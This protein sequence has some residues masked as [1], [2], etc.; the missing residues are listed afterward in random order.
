MLLNTN[1]DRALFEGAREERSAAGI[2]PAQARAAMHSLLDGWAQRHQTRTALREL[3]T[4]LR[5]CVDTQASQ[6]DLET[7]DPDDVALVPSDVL[8]RLDSVERID[9]PRRCNADAV[10]RWACCPP[11]LAVLTAH[12]IQA[13]PNRALDLRAAGRLHTFATTGELQVEAAINVTIHRKT[14]EPPDKPLVIRAGSL[15]CTT[16]ESFMSHANA[17]RLA[18][19]GQRAQSL[20]A[21]LQVMC[22]DAFHAEMN[23]L[24]AARW[25][26]AAALKGLVGLILDDDVIFAAAATA[27]AAA[28]E[29]GAPD[30]RHLPALFS[31]CLLAV[32]RHSS[33]A[34]SDSKILN[35]AQRLAQRLEATGPQAQVDA[36]SVSAHLRAI[37]LLS[38]SGVLT[39]AN[40]RVYAAAMTLVA[41]VDHA[42]FTETATLQSLADAF[43]GLQ[44]ICTAGV[45]SKNASVL[46]A[47]GQLA[48]LVNTAPAEAA[49][50][51]EAVPGAMDGL[52]SAL[53]MN[54]VRADQ[55]ALVGAVARLAMLATHMAHH[56]PAAFRTTARCLQAFGELVHRHALPDES[57]RE[58]TA[59]ALFQ[60]LREAVPAEMARATDCA[61]AL[62]GI[63]TLIEAH[64]LS[65]RT[66]GLSGTVERLAGNL[67]GAPGDTGPVEVL[68][69]LDHLSHL[70]DS[71]AIDDTSLLQACARLI[72]GIAADSMLAA[73]LG[74]LA[75]GLKALGD[76]AAK[77][78][79]ARD[80]RALQT[81][82]ACLTACG[83]NQ[84]FSRVDATSVAP[85]GQAVQHAARQGLLDHSFLQ[86]GFA[87]FAAQNSRGTRRTEKI[88]SL[89]LMAVSHGWLAMPARVS[90]LL[91]DRQAMPAPQEAALMVEQGVHYLRRERILCADP[92]RW[93][94]DR[95]VYNEIMRLAP[96]LPWHAMAEHGPALRSVCEHLDRL[97]KSVTALG[98]R[99]AAALLND[100]LCR[101]AVPALAAWVRTR[102]PA[103]CTDATLLET[104]LVARYLG[105][106]LLPPHQPIPPAAFKCIA[107]SAFIRMSGAPRALPDSALDMP[108]V[109]T[110]GTPVRDRT[111]DAEAGP[112]PHALLSRRA[113]SL[114]RTLLG[115]D[116]PPPLVVQL[117]AEELERPGDIPAHV[118]HQGQWYRIDLLRGGLN[119]GD[120]DSPP[121][122]L[123]VPVSATGFFNHFL[124]TSHE[125][126]FYAQRALLPEHAERI[127]ASQQNDR[128]LQPQ[129]AGR[130][131]MAIVPADQAQT[132]FVPRGDHAHLRAEDGC[133]FIRERLARQLLG[134]DGYD[135]L[136]LGASRQSIQPP[137]RKGVPLTALQ[138]YVAPPEPCEEAVQ[139]FQ[140]SAVQTL[141]H[142]LDLLATVPPLHE[143]QAAVNGRL[144]NLALTAYPVHDRGSY[145]IVLPDTDQFRRLAD[146][147]VIMGRNPYDTRSLCRIEPD[148]IAFSPVPTAQLQVS[149]TGFAEGGDGLQMQFYKGLLALLPESAWPEGHSQDIVF[150]SKD[151]KLHTGFTSLAE[152]ERIQTTG[153]RSVS[154]HGVLV[155]K[156]IRTA[157]V[158]VTPRLQE[159]GLKG[160][161]DGDYDQV[162]APVP[163]LWNLIGAP[164]M[165]PK[166]PKTFTPDHGGSDAEKVIQLMGG[167][168]QDASTLEAQYHALPVEMAGAVRQKLHATHVLRQLFPEGDSWIGCAGLPDNLHS[169]DAGLQAEL[170]VRREIEILHK[171]GT[172][173]EKTGLN[174]ALIDLRREEYK[175]ILGPN[176]RKPWSLRG[177]EAASRAFA[178]R[179]LSTAEQK[180][181][182]R[183]VLGRQLDATLVLNDQMPNRI[184]RRILE[185][186]LGRAPEPPGHALQR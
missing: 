127:A 55:L 76:L 30:L 150:T 16:V 95:T 164:G 9:L 86:A 25:K 23:A 168:V 71:P 129:L 157:S 99:I 125:S 183:D 35:A 93:Q 6:L 171:A 165:N 146:Q 98:D 143:L 145:R 108:I 80:P 51:G 126:R 52:V 151:V 105:Q 62:Q 20:A 24:M 26:G 21:C 131:E 3:C 94:A 155:V 118:Q 179:E 83:M 100:L 2:A 67:P 10:E 56:G 63:R 134:D 163:G 161:F 1:V 39:R 162:F 159:E 72:A 115:D 117:R 44:D 33:I 103:P 141:R 7:F 158:G 160:D 144:H 148:E 84:D 81:A 12:D 186:F 58:E 185:W 31:R 46:Q 78:A 41:A 73:P 89:L 142:P 18:G 181:L 170:I 167:L 107:E 182:I 87:S 8:A 49:S 123:G 175:A 43:A 178:S 85:F 50:L 92:G 32:A 122:F 40:S 28:G 177:L 102:Q 22:T 38:G 114:W 156:D 60:R 153:D 17:L 69:S 174:F 124:F 97:Q 147:G 13:A 136:M 138:F 68:G 132:A 59:T 37:G 11:R 116:V 48:Q 139:A 180:A 47:F 88:S 184:S 169:L 19:G 135:A 34:A 172:D 74:L 57:L 70:A 130:F 27:P 111:H 110:D 133:G 4:L 65:D 154:L 79:F 54:A 112:L 75:I 29:S 119:K 53:Q 101:R 140:A 77:N 137:A 66:P 61:N 90:S 149:L 106:P 113:T 152:K 64:A 166:L 91:P 36:P 82:A 128:P 104:S 176:Q 14:P 173:Q 45:M 5:A 121:Q 120:R 42:G 96:R 109:Y 15:R